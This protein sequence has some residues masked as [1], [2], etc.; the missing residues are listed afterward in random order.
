MAINAELR[1]R[2]ALMRRLEKLAPNVEKY[3]ATV[4]LEIAKE[5]AKRIADAAPK[6]TGEYAA[7]IKAEPIAN[8][9]NK[10]QVGITQTKD[11]TAA[12][13][14]APWFW[15]FLEFGTAPHNTAPGGG[16]KSYSGPVNLHPGTAARPHVFT[17]WRAMK[18]KAGRKI[19]AAVNKAVRE[20]MGKK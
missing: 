19:R 7:N 9:P 17:T 2:D 11:P 5:A 16:N 6:N 12:G 14:Y 1:G 4:K 13:I 3:A 10:K 8:N 20:A 18:K 15:H